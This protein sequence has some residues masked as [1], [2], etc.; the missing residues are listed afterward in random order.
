M[1]AGLAQ[2]PDGTPAGLRVA[3]IDPGGP[4]AHAG[5]GAGDLITKVDGERLTSS[6]QL[7]ALT[8]KKRPGATLRLEVERSG[9]T[10][11]ATVTL[12]RAPQSADSQT[13]IG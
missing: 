3:A 4:A 12:G 7:V 13:Q 2:G 9:A 5:I 11:E 1:Q 8:L 6:D 10:H